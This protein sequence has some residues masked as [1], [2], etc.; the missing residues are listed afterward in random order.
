VKSKLLT[1]AGLAVAYVL[2]ARL[3]LA[4][5]P[6]WTR[7]SPAWPPAGL[8]LAAML[9]L[10]WQA[11]PGVALGAF[12]ESATGP[13]AGPA[14]RLVLVAASAGVAL[15]NTIEALAGAWL[16]RRFAGGRAA[17]ERPRSIFRFLALGALL[18]TVIGPALSVGSLSLAR[19]LGGQN[20]GSLWFAWWLAD[21]VSVVVVTPLL[22]AW[23]TRP[24]P[25]MDRKRMTELVA[26][27]LLLGALCLVFF[28][29]WLAAKTGP[30]LP[31]YLLVPILLWPALRLGQTGAT[32]TIFVFWCLALIGTARGLD[33]LAVGE[34]SPSMFPLQAFIGV[35]AVMALVLAANV[36]QH[37]KEV[38]RLNAELERR[39]SERTAQLEAMNKELEAFSYSVSHDLRAPLRSILGFSEVLLERY[40]SQL[41]ASGQGFLRRAC[42]SCQQMDN[43]IQDLLKLSRVG[44]SEMR[45]QP[46]NLS[47]LAESI[48]DGLRKAEPDR[49]ADFLIAPNLCAQG[50]ERLLRVALDNLLRN[51]WKFTRYKPRASIQFGTVANPGGQDARPTRGRAPIQL[52]TVANPQFAFFVRDN[53]AGF[54][55]ARAGKLFGVFQRLH[56][57]SEFPGSGVGLATVQRIIN[58]HGGLAWAVAAPDQGA[59]FFFTLP[60]TTL[61]PGELTENSAA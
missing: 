58:R 21:G 36:T 52:G 47:A 3:G 53:G 61:S 40:A 57:A 55:M 41:D 56:S 8:A 4:L 24:F 25:L 12:L 60:Q 20:P 31:A 33:P 50:D 35:S 51:A 15:G 45:R 16:V 23:G 29:G 5:G 54:D 37:A 49:P 6:G 30:V 14:S 11:W 10:G 2:S 48:A 22:L 42:E 7:A 19:L 38:R 13:V 26:V 34:W 59:T 44:R 46:V 18:S 27:Q 17:L 28:G 43:L 39:V 32:L 9:L 1:V